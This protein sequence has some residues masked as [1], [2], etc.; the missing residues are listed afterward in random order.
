MRLVSNL[1][2]QPTVITIDGPSGSGKG[3]IALKVAQA[4][5]WHI[6]D[7]GII[8]RAVAWALSYYGISLEDQDGIDHLIKGLKIVV[9]SQLV[10]R[11]IKVSCDNHDITEAI[12]SEECSALASK[13]SA[14]SVVRQAVLQYQ[15]DFSRWPGLVADG[16]DM[17][18]V[19]FPYA[20]LKFYFNADLQERAYRRYRQLQERGINVSLRNI[21]EDLEER[22]YRDVS[23]KISPTKPAEDALIINTTSLNIKEVFVAV[24]N[25]IK[26]RKLGSR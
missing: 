17:G 3:T 9:E 23:R 26:E 21:R 1:E 6:L 14:L 8:Y 20:T 15:R 13:S 10:V 11:K 2:K 22:D 7:S 24:M 5:H 4:L 25:H 12:R 16:R 19:V 18:T